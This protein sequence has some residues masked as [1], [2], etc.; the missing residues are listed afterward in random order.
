MDKQGNDGQETDALKLDTGT[1]SLMED[2][3]IWRKPPLV[4]AAADFMNKY[5]ISYMTRSSIS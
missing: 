5:L 1:L 3:Y 2:R 4:F